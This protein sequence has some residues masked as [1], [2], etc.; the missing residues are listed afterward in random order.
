MMPSE[1][2]GAGAGA[3][4]ESEAAR[5]PVDTTTFL[6][7]RGGRSQAR[8]LRLDG[9]V[10]VFG[11]EFSGRWGGGRRSPRELK[12]RKFAFA[13]ALPSYRPQLPERLSI[14]TRVGPFAHKDVSF[15]CLHAR[16]SIGDETYAIVLRVH[17]QAPVNVLT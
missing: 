11:E 17:G 8:G 13:Q 7:F 12:T 6:V 15:I 9:R 10:G 3:A 5:C 2:A 14:Q 16:G 4:A 1:A